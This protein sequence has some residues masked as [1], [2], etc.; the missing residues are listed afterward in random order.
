MDLPFSGVLVWFF[1]EFQESDSFKLIIP[2]DSISVIIDDIYYL[3]NH[4]IM[5]NKITEKLNNV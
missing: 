1:L 5:T 4:G 3:Y 2:K